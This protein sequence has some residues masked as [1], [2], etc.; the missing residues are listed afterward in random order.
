MRVKVD[1][2]EVL[3]ENGHLEVLRNGQKW[4]DC[5]GDNL[6]L[7]L[8]YAIEDLRERV[9]ELEQELAEAKRCSQTG[10]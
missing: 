6:L 5:T 3:F 7:C 4:R 2:Y 9:A 1:Q 10:S 8:T